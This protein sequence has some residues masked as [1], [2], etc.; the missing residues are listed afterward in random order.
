MKGQSG[1]MMYAGQH[2]A[3]RRLAGLSDGG[4]EYLYGRR[5]GE[6]IAAAF[7]RPGR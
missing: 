4:K 6:Y 7:T 2:A 1:G 5:S 3:A